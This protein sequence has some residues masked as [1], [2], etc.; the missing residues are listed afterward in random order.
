MGTDTFRNGPDFILVE[1]IRP[2]DEIRAQYETLI[3]MAE[4]YEGHDNGYVGML[5]GAA[6]ALKWVVGEED[7]SEFSGPDRTSIG[8]PQ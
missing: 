4:N 7:G 3:D 1:D 6:Y 5:V 2:I 8:V